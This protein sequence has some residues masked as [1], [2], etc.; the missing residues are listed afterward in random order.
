MAATSVQSAITTSGAPNASGFGIILGA[1]PTPGNLLVASV[2]CFQGFSSV[3]AQ[4][5]DSGITVTDG[6]ATVMKILYRYVQPGD[7]DTF[8]FGVPNNPAFWIA[9]VVELTGVTGTWAVDVSGSRVGTPSSATNPFTTT[10]IATARVNAL[11]LCFVEWPSTPSPAGT[12]SAGWTVLAAAQPG[13]AAGLA[14]QAFATAGSNVQATITAA[15]IFDATFIVLLIEPFVAPAPPPRISQA[16]AKFATTDDFSPPRIQQAVAKFAMNANP[17][18][19]RVSQAVV[20][21]A[22]R[23]YPRIAI[24][25]K[26]PPIRTTQKRTAYIRSQEIKGD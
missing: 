7:T 19:I 10:A 24:A 25:K 2:G 14:E 3:G 5:V 17:D 21:V 6:N 9:T 18:D 11:A 16:V 1:V 22:V 15:R 23:V 4:W 8:S 12:Y 26:I 20:K 13:Y